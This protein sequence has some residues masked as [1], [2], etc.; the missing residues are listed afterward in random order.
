MIRRV[1][2]LVLA[3]L[4]AFP[5]SSFAGDIRASVASLPDNA[6]VALHVI[7]LEELTNRDIGNARKQQLELEN[8]RYE[9]AIAAGLR[10]LEDTVFYTGAIASNGEEELVWIVEK[11]VRYHT[12]S[13]CCG[14]KDP[15][16]VAVSRAIVKGLTPCQDCA[17][18][19]IEPEE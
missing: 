8:K 13:D 15:Q 19:M 14:M 6:L 9:E 17:Y 5:C 4:L 1:V 7:V 16:Q 12:V 11:G 10:I 18:A 2:C 3:L